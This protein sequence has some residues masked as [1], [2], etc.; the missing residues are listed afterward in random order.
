MIGVTSSGHVRQKRWRADIGILLS[1]LLPLVIAGISLFVHVLRIL[2]AKGDQPPVSFLPKG[3]TPSVGRQAKRFAK[4]GDRSLSKIRK[5]KQC[6]I[7]DFAHLR[8]GLQAGR[9]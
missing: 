6:L 5:A 3:L 2:H 4:M 7:R 8:H 1:H 9:K